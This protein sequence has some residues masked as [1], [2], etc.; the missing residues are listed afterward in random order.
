MDDVFRLKDVPKESIVSD[1]VDESC[2][3]PRSR[4]LISL[5]ELE[6]AGLFISE[7]L[8]G[9]GLKCERVDLGSHGKGIV[10]TAELT[11]LVEK[12]TFQ[13]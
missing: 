2:D 13:V 9:H 10:V 1:S 3:Q 8:E 5:T 11:A 12:V 6:W 7:A 4:Y